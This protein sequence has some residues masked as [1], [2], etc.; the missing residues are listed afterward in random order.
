MARRHLCPPL[1]TPETGSEASP[2]AYWLCGPPSRIDPC[3]RPALGPESELGRYGQGP[4]RLG[5]PEHGLE[6]ERVGSGWA[7]PLAPADTPS[8]EEGHGWKQV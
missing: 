7:P 5:D 8:H 4:G 3:K 2:Q 1:G 6:S